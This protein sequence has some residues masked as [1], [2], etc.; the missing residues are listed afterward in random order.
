MISKAIKALATTK[1]LEGKTYSDIN[2]ELGTN[3][4]KS[5]LSSWFSRMPL[6]MASQ[7]KLEI[8][9]AKKLEV[10]QYKGKQVLKKKRKKYLQ[11]LK[12]KNLYLL[13]SI[14]TPVQKIIL[15]T[16]YL[17]EGTKGRS[18]LTLG[19]SN[20]KIISLYLSLLKNCFEIDKSKFRIRIQGRADQN[21]ILLE[22]FWQKVTGVPTKQFYPTYT[23]QRTRG[24]K[25]LKKNYR[26][27]CVVHYF[28]T[29]IELEL[30]LL[31]D[32][33]INYLVPG[34]ISTACVPSLPFG[35]IA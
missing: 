34:P 33:M 24:K 7:K 23:D 21:P 25:T 3:L 5:T 31:A 1:R 4:S 6:S 18:C 27:V 20:P 11:T 19:S 14:S 28:D 8:N 13:K 15:S 22:G 9:I 29:S 2:R 26:G 10:A 30:E 16:L 32:S 17:A 35:P 12:N